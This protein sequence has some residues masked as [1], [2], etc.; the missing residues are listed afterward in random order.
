MNAFINVII[1]CVATNEIT[2]LVH[3]TRGCCFALQF[4]SVDDVLAT[5]SEF[6]VFFTTYGCSVPLLHEFSVCYC[7]N[8]RKSESSADNG[9]LK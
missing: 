6:I 4:E 7:K 2:R 5:I 9:Y 3:K 8:V 1:K